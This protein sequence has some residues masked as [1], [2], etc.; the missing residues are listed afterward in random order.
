MTEIIIENMQDL[1]D[2]DRFVFSVG[3][4]VC[5]KHWI[6]TP[7]SFSKAGETISENEKEIVYTALY[8]HEKQI[9]AVKAV[10]EAKINLNFCPV[11][12]TLVCDSCFMICDDIDMCADCARVLKVAGEPVDA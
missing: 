11:C 4:A 5:G 9:A 12:K 3:C 6:S 7:V 1:S 10:K 2:K 8:Q